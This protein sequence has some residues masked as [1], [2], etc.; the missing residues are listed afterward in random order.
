MTDRMTDTTFCKLEACSELLVGNLTGITLC[1]P[2]S[3]HHSCSRIL[4]NVV[5]LNLLEGKL[6]KKHSARSHPRDGWQSSSRTKVFGVFHD[7]FLFLPDLTERIEQHT[8]FMTGAGKQT[9]LGPPC[10]LLDCALI[11]NTNCRLSKP[12]H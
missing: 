5:C 7:Q 10:L 9:R 3:L 11:P 12:Q 8:Y 6:K 2:S 1:V 4:L